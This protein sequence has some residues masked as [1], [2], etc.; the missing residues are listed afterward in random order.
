M[1]DNQNDCQAFVGSHLSPAQ[2]AVAYLTQALIVTDLPTYA[3]LATNDSRFLQNMMTSSCRVT[4][5][6]IV[7]HL[8]VVFNYVALTKRR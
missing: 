4:I 7:P 1:F 3:T 6:R 8:N 2:L 5:C